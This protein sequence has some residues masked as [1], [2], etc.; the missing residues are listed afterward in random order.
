[1][2]GIC[3]LP[4]DTQAVGPFSVFPSHTPNPQPSSQVPP[5]QPLQAFSA[6]D[7]LVRKTSM[8]LALALLL[9]FVFSCPDLVAASPS[10]SYSL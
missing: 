9:I 7:P 4:L 8:W 3:S 6:L 1:M 5:Q 10:P 2:P